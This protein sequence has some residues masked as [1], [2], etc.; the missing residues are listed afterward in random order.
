RLPV[1]Q[2]AMT[3]AVEAWTA[4][5]LTHLGVDSVFAPYVLGMLDMETGPTSSYDDED[6]KRQE[7]LD[8]LMGWLDDSHQAQAEN[9]VDE[10][11]LYIKNPQQLALLND[12]PTVVDVAAAAAAKV[13]EEFARLN[14]T[15]SSFAHADARTIDGT[16]EDDAFEFDVDDE[17]AFYWSVAYEL[18]EQLLLVF[19]VMDPERLLDLL[20]EVDLNVHRAQ[21]TMQGIVDSELSKGNNAQVCRHYLQ[22]DCRRADCWFLHDTHLI[23]CRYWIRGGCLQGDECAFAH[24]FAVAVSQYSSSVVADTDEHDDEEPLEWNFPALGGL[25]TTVSD[26]GLSLNFKRAVAMAPTSSSSYGGSNSWFGS[27]TSA[28]LTHKK[29]SSVPGKSTMSIT[30]WVET[31]DQVAVQYQRARATA[32]D[33]ALARNQCFMNATRAFRANNKAAAKTLSRQGQQF[34]AEMKQAHFEAATIIFNARNPQYEVDG[35]VDLHGLHVVE[36]VE[37]LAWLLPSIKTREAICVVTGSGHHSHHQRLRPAVERFLTTEG[38][39]FTVVPDRKG[40]VGMLNS[41]ADALGFSETQDI[42]AFVDSIESKEDI[43][44]AVVQMIGEDK[45]AVAHTIAARLVDERRP[46]VVSTATGAPP[47][48]DTTPKPRL[49]HASPITNCLECGFIEYGGSPACASCGV[50]LHY[51][52]ERPD[53][54]EAREHRDRLLANDASLSQRT[55]VHD[56]NAHFDADKLARDDAAAVASAM[57]VHIDLVNRSIEAAPMASD[58]ADMMAS[59]VHHLERDVRKVAKGAPPPLVH[60][61]NYTV[62]N[63]DGIADEYV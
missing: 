12:T 49:P 20:K 16:A 42:A 24:S 45:S 7:V 35:I 41:L 44:E 26:D 50:L 18:V 21:A 62:V 10:L 48:V 37:L 15:A 33:L 1:V 22:G 63:G 25:T 54:H 53:A 32:R 55:V 29:Q 43:Y 27:A 5:Q 13:E 59:L 17:E 57:T 58:Q 14:A 47:A 40:Y 9:F 2:Q 28:N 52:D 31:G 39:T 23:P 11:I 6:E 36:A 60:H 51:V 56:M 19:P 46:K 8:L 3:T 61:G 34:N 38:Y 4:K 30:Q